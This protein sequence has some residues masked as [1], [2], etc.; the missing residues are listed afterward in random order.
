MKLKSEK[1]KKMNELEL[2]RS[3]QQLRIGQWKVR[4]EI[5]FSIGR[6]PKSID[7]HLR[8]LEI[9]CRQ[10][11][12]IYYIIIYDEQIKR[13][14]R[15][16]ARINLYL[17]IESAESSSLATEQLSL[18]LSCAPN[19]IPFVVPQIEIRSKSFALLS[20]PTAPNL[21]SP[22]F[23]TRSASKDVNQFNSLAQWRR[24]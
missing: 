13:R 6:S 18:R 4:T 24:R 10:N 21:C 8:S 17:E 3:K 1:K 19:W 11:R 22:P 7:A 12:I 14:R 23:R 16:E 9:H 20:L 5:I 15:I 2:W